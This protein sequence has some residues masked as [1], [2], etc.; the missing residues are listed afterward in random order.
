MEGYG[1]QRWEPAEAPGAPGVRQERE[2]GGLTCGG[3]DTA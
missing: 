3:S 2:G 1:G